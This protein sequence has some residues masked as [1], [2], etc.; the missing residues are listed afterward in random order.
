MSAWGVSTS[1]CLGCSAWHLGGGSNHPS[2][3]NYDMPAHRCTPP[4]GGLGLCPAVRRA[5]G[6]ARGGACRLSPSL[7][8]VPAR[9]AGL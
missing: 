5:P 3:V 6:A 9:L 7:T 1:S 4:D 2:A 8:R